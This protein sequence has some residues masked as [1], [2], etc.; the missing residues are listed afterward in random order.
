MVASLLVSVARYLPSHRTT[1]RHK[2]SLR[3]SQMPYTIV[4]RKLRSK[5]DAPHVEEAA[6]GA[7][8]TCALFNFNRPRARLTRGITINEHM[9]IQ[10]FSSIATPWR[11]QITKAF[12]TRVP[13]RK[14]RPPL[15]QQIL[16]LPITKR[17]G[18]TPQELLLKL[19]TSF[20][21]N[22]ALESSLSNC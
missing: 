6:Q 20:V 1:P 11:P 18:I 17:P 7:E 19:K 9:K 3:S 12:A 22:L 21:K 15:T 5:R 10:L 8:N 13:A 14:T 4:C 2:Q 16:T